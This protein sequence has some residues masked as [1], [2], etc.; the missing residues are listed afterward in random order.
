MEQSSILT[1]LNP[2]QR[3]AVLTTE[4]PVLILAGAG[5]GKTRVVTQRI[6]YLLAEKR[7]APWSILA[8]TFTNK[9]AREMK[10]R[11]SQL[12]GAD[13]EDIWISTFHSMCV[14]ILRRDIERIG[15]SS[16]FTILDSTDQLSQVKDILK[17]LNIDPKRFD[18]R[19]ILATISQAKNALQ[20]PEEYANLVGDPFMKVV[21]DVYTEY[22]RRL[23]TNQSLDF[24]DLLMVTVQLFKKVPEVLEYYQK[25]F[26]YIHVDEYQDTNAVQ[27]QLVHL[28]A[29]S[30]QNICVVGDTDQSIYSWRGADITNILRFEE[31]YPDAQVILLEQNYR[32][33]KRILQAANEVIRNNTER[34]EKN[35]WTE[36]EDG[37]LIQLY[38]AETEHDEA[39][40]I[41]EQL[42]KKLQEGASYQDF[43][44]LYRTN[45]QSR[46]IEEVLIKSS[47]PY[48]L[49]GGTRF[50]ERKEIRDVMA[51]LK[52]VANPHDDASFKRIVNVPKRGIG[53]TSLDKLSQYAFEQ[54]I[55]LYTAASSAEEAGVS[56]KAAGQLGAFAEMIR[57]LSG[58][59]DY[60]SVHE[61]TEQV[62]ERSRYIEELQQEKTIE[63]QT[64]IE[65]I[66]EFLSV[67]LDFEK[68]SEDHSLIS[69]LSDV[70]L[71]AD[72]DQ[73]DEGQK[74]ITLMTLHSAK[75]LEFP[76][77]FLVGM[78][79]GLFPHNRALSDEHEMEEE[80]RLAYVGITRAEKGLYLTYARSRTIYG[81]IQSMPASRFIDEIPEEL[82]ER[83]GK[84]Q[85]QAMFRSST[86]LRSQRI[87]PGADLT[88]SWKVGEKVQHGKWGIGTIVGCKGEGDN[89]ELDIAF[90]GM[91]I[92]KL[93]AKFAPIEKA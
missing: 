74:R 64:R 88:L 25:K 75:G 5:S 26:R 44:I 71:V 93:L 16:R 51:Y 58:Q 69:F 11:V 59:V 10:E 18:P 80:R 61:L 49:V 78:E 30:H 76:Y 50:Y 91:G 56:G 33:T 20:S 55:S 22:Q 13:A 84:K 43:A 19:A 8:I 35:L 70:A 67:T 27:Y 31:D 42:E 12:V 39:Y 14:R 37:P 73:W 23:K 40:Y 41:V 92:K 4:G 79:E 6:A 3:R 38:E 66:Q 24:D 63:A 36:N 86:S 46:I 17:V 2:E 52:L 47:H 34:K 53:A 28:L 72:V 82:L 60:Q 45:A 89:L 32:S 62:L 21:S 68:K 85:Q 87:H 7:V 83:D 81:R 77:V 9:A 54:G 15:Y 48:Q 1:G 29:A 90:P 57:E 65:N